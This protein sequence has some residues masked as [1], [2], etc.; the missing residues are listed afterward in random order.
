MAVAHTP[1]GGIHMKVAVVSSRSLVRHALCALLTKAGHFHEVMEFDS[2]PAPVAVDNKS[3]PLVFLVH[4]T[5]PRT[6]LNS[7]RELRELLPEARGILL[8]NDPDE[9]LCMHALE[10]GAW[11]CLSTTEEPQ[12]LLKALIKVAAG[13][14]WFGRRITNIVIERTISS[15]GMH[16]KLVGNLTPR[17]WQ[18]LALLAK[19]YSDKEVASHLFISTE[20]EHS[21]VKSIFKKLQVDTRRAA[22]VCYFRNVHAH[23]GLSKSGQPARASSVE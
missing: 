3:Q 11:G 17:E 16:A 19:G 23:D 15:Q 14:R 4:A 20:T 18:V 21:H 8:A 12:V 13:E 22:A 2:I 7:V 10:A 1:I 6:G 5:D 9:E